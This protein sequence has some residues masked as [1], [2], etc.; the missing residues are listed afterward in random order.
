MIKMKIK[1]IDSYFSYNAKEF[2]QR[3]REFEIF[4]QGPYSHFFFFLLFFLYFILF[5]FF[6]F[7]FFFFH[8]LPRSKKEDAVLSRS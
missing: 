5:S 6:F 7:F 1:N 3:T 4:S 8:R 2:S